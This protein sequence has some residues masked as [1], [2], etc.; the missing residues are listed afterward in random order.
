MRNTYII[1]LLV[2]TAFTGRAQVSTLENGHGVVSYYT[3][4]NQVNWFSNGADANNTVIQDGTTVETDLDGGVD[5]ILGKQVYS[6]P[7]VN[8]PQ[9]QRVP[10][11]VVRLSPSTSVTI[12]NTH[13]Q[14]TGIDE[15]ATRQITLNHG[16][17]AVSLNKSSKLSSLRIVYNGGVIVASDAVFSL[18]SEGALAVTAGS[19]TVIQ[20]G[21]AT[22]VSAGYVS[23]GGQG[24][25]TPNI[26]ANY[27]QTVT[28]VK[29]NTQTYV[30]PTQG[31][32]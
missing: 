17:I 13:V 3:D 29:D 11:S 16:V 9:Q 19:V 22:Q 20:N 5:I 18:S 26:S 6:T 31:A 28:H 15:V 12:D 23:A 24:L 21:K 1:A 14:Y 10:Q 4:T 32:K 27:W 30:S 8:Q 25:P 7:P 2:T